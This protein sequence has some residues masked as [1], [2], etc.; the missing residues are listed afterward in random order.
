[1]VVALVI[2]VATVIWGLKGI[3]SL[4]AIFI[5]NDLGDVGDIE[6]KPTPPIISDIPEATYSAQ[7]RITGFAQPGIEV[8]LYMNGARLAQK[9]TSDSG[10]FEFVGVPIAEGENV[11]YA[12]SQASNELLS[13]KSKEYIIVLDTTKPNVTLQ[14]P[15]DGK[16]FRGQSERIVNFEGVVNEYGSRVFIGERMA[17]LTPEGKFSLPYQLVE[18]DQEIQIRVVDKAGNEEISA[19]KLR[20]EP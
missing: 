8:I 7:V 16:I 12:Y 15:S 17:I 5:N 1:M 19:I 4:S 9:L 2:I 18:G 10:T 14:S 3:A 20:W 13:E 11:V 6:L